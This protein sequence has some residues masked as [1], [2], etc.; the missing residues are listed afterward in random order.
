MLQTTLLG[1]SKQ[2]AIEHTST[3]PLTTTTMIIII[4][5]KQW[6]IEAKNTLPLTQVIIPTITTTTIIIIKVQ[7]F[8]QTIIVDASSVG[9]KLHDFE[10]LGNPYKIPITTKN[11]FR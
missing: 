6:G 3:S 1:Y 7:N 5:I 2:Q 4:I 9:R 10:I 8:Y 11:T